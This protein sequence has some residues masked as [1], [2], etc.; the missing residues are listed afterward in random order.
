MID[1]ASQSST[2]LVTA[3][4]LAFLNHRCWLRMRHRFYQP[5]RRFYILNLIITIGVFLPGISYSAEQKLE[6]KEK[7]EKLVYED[8][9]IK[10]R[11]ITRSPKQIA[12]FYEG[13][14][15]NK[16]AI[17]ETNHFCFPAVIVINKTSDTLWLNL[18]NWTFLNN[19]KPIKRIKRNYW[20]KRWQAINLSNSH[21]STFG[22]TLMPEIR[23]LRVDEG[24]GGSIP[25]E[26]QSHPF[27]LH[28]RFKTG[29]DKQGPEISVIMHNI[30]CP[31]D[32]EET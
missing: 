21:Q 25:I 14:E 5:T 2:L 10:M 1:P 24:V 29:Q 22:W 12:A 13:R 11:I 32:K 30:P 31:K 4:I 18:E 20:K 7:K 9:N 28:A 27:T 3:T 8:K 23:D 15:F 16:A 26:M 19:E 17:K 6:A